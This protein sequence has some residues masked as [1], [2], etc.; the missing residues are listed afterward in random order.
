[1]KQIPIASTP[2]QTLNVTLGAQSCKI[3]LY[4]KSTGVY[5]DLSIDNAP[6]ITAVLCLD[7]VK[8]VRHK[9]LGFIGSLAFV[10][11]QGKTDPDYTGFG[12][13]YVLIY[14]EPGDIT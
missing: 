8:L 3:N 5:L 11:T 7:R 6:I 9:Y 14:L 13:R 12:A 1:M 2:S 4:Q 10:D